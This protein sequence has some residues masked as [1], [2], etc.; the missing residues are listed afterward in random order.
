MRSIKSQS[1]AEYRLLQPVG[2]QPLHRTTRTTNIH[3]ALIFESS[4]PEATSS[5]HQIS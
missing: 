4:P 2:T 3:S 5:A 1:T